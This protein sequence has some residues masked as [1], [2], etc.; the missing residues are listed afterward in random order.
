MRN[1]EHRKTVYG[2]PLCDV[3]KILETHGYAVIP[4]ADIHNHDLFIHA[5]TKDSS[6]PAW[7]Q[8][9]ASAARLPRE[10]RQ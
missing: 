9:L 8:T 7:I 2:Y 1:G 5:L 6:I 10:S 3:I 4:K